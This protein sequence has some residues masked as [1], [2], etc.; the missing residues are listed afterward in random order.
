MFDGADE[1]SIVRASKYFKSFDLNSDGELTI[2]EFKTKLAEWGMDG[3]D[4]H[5]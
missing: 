4:V 2:A 1:E 3:A 5:K